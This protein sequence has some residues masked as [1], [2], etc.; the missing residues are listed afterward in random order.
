[1]NTLKSYGLTDRFINEA[2]MYEGFKL[3]R[4]IAQY[5]GLYKIITEDGEHLAEISGKLRYET[6]ELA[7]F[8]AVGD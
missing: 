8:P 1:M 6:T 7:K 2:S 5:K 4:V 3:A